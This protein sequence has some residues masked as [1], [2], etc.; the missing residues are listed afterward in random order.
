M[1]S[2]THTAVHRCM[3]HSAQTFKHHFFK[4]FETRKE[5]VQVGDALV[6]YLVCCGQFTMVQ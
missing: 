6:R 1:Y 5:G 2:T 3:R 4:V